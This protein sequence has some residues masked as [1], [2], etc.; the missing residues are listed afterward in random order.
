MGL[1]HS[2]RVARTETGAVGRRAG[3]PS[4]SNDDTPSAR[5]EFR[6]P[7]TLAEA[8]KERAERDGVSVSTV[9]RAA[10]EQ[11]LEAC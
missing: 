1:T 10:L 7:P 11:Y 5:V 3:R 8:A 6:V 9:A 4:L 2:A